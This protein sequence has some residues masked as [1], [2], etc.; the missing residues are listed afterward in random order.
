[1]GDAHRQ[2]IRAYKAGHPIII[3]GH[4]AGGAAAR[5]MAARLDNASIPVRLLVTLA[6]WTELKVPPNVQR[7]INIVPTGYENHFTVILAHERELIRYV[8]AAAGVGPT[9]KDQTRHAAH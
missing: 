7:S 4:S 9:G 3:V 6:P 2:A 5:A 8:T 1:M